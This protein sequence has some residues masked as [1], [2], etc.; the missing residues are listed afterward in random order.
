M[1]DARKVKYNLVQDNI[2][3]QYTENKEKMNQ[4]DIQKDRRK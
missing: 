3:E 4:E 1:K 2:T